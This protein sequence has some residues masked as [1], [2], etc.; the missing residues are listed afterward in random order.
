MFRMGFLYFVKRK[1]YVLIL[2]LLLCSTYGSIR[3]AY[4]ENS[5]TV[6]ITGDDI[7]VREQLENGEIPSDDVPAYIGYIGIANEQNEFYS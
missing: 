5:R 7:K 3:G 6:W 4:K 2:M 1:W